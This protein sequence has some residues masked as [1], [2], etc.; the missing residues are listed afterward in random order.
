VFVQALA[1]FVC[2]FLVYPD[3]DKWCQ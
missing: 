1:C 2:N 3:I